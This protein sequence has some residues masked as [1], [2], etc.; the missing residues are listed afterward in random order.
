MSIN[1][2]AE[3]PNFGGYPIFLVLC[4]ENCE[5]HFLVSTS[6]RCPATNASEHQGNQKIY[7]RLIILLLHKLPQFAI[8]FL[9]G[10][11]SIFKRTPLEEALRH[12]E[13]Y[14]ITLAYLKHG[15]PIASL[16]CDFVSDRKISSSVMNYLK[17]FYCNEERVKEFMEVCGGT[18]NHRTSHFTRW[19]NL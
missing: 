19:F 2:G 1:L 15:S 5:F 13:M 9:L 17:G 11:R 12:D 14:H 3:P 4:G 18:T 6:F 16:E 8:H 7:E 10:Q